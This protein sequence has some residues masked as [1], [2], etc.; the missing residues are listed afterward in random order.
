MDSQLSKQPIL[1]TGLNEITISEY[2]DVVFNGKMDCLIISG[3]PTKDDLENAKNEILCNLSEELSGNALNASLNSWRKI[4]LFKSRVS[5][6]R[7]CV[8]LIEIGEIE[9]ALSYLKPFNIRTNNPH[10]IFKQI[11]SKYKQTVSSLGECIEL[12]KKRSENSSNNSTL[13]YF[14]DQLT[15][16]SQNMGY[17]IDKK[18]TTL[19]EYASYI[20]T[21][22]KQLKDGSAKSDTNTAKRPR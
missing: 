22:R 7:I 18:T 10:D 11:E 17:R 21:I 3:C 14:E 19:S 8:R 1:K 4:H 15:S 12:Y 5:I 16:I 6:L 2:I 20:R 9:T 13:S